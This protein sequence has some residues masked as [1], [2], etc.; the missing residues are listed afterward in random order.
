M[1][2]FIAS[3]VILFL[4]TLIPIYSFSDFELTNSKLK[5][6]NKKLGISILYPS[7]WQI[8]QESNNTV[9]LNIPNQQYKFFSDGKIK[10]LLEKIAKNVSLNEYFE[11]K[12]KNI[13]EKFQE[14]Q[15]NEDPDFIF[16]IINSNYSTYSNQSS[17]QIIYEYQI[18]S[19]LPKYGINKELVIWAIKSDTG[20]T[21]TYSAK[22][23]NFDKYIDDAKKI[24]SSI[25]F[26]K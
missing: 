9:V 3:I 22:K 8:A 11:N 20:Y 6:D 15:I 13:K 10:I 4:I 18:E 14:I 25:R 7:T 17:Y 1:Y 23:E 19:F 21:I 26:I 12:I 16:N 5:Y 24:V 2:I